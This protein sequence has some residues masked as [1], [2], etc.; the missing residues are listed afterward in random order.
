[1][2]V[3]CKAMQQAKALLITGT[4]F[5]SE[6]M[7]LATHH[8]LDV[9]RQCG[10]AVIL[11]LDFR[12]VLWGL[13]EKGAGESRYESCQKVTAHYQKI[14]PKCDLI[15]G[16]EEE[17]LIAG[18]GDDLE[19]AMKNIRQLVDA[20][21]ILKRGEKGCEIHLSGDQSPISGQSFP[22][23]VL[24]VLGAGDAFMSG[25]LSGWLRQEPW[26]TCAQYANACGAVV[27]TRHGLFA[28]HS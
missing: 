2:I 23:T 17:V 3:M 9:A 28:C 12:P 15:V 27:V 1:M 26:E 24:N 13:T 6:S 14:V 16:T 21:I 18:G 10:T 8:A 4:G 19:Q 7:R 25:F 11:D 5:S 22:I 20:P